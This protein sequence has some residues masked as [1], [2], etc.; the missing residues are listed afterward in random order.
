MGSLGHRSVKIVESW[1]ELEAHAHARGAGGR[2]VGA[3]D[4]KTYRWGR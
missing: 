2:S 1:I 4:D 3:N